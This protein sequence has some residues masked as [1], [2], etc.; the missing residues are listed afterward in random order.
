MAGDGRLPWSEVAAIC[1]TRLL[2]LPPVGT[3]LATGPARPPRRL[4]LP[5]EL[6]DLLRYGR[7]IDNRRL[8]E[9]GFDYRY[10]SAGAVQASSGP[11]GCA[12]SIG[13]S[14]RPYTLRARRRAVLPPLARGGPSGDR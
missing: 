13:P 6:I 12:A 9:A 3:G 11:S 7:G 8:E 5:A 4:R 2:P 10:T 14:P 1:G